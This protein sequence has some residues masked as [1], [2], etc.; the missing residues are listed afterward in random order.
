MGLSTGIK[1]PQP[2]GKTRQILMNTS[3]SNSAVRVRDNV[4]VFMPAQ[5]WKGAPS[6]TVSREIARQWR[7]QGLADFVNKG[8]G[9][10]LK[11]IRPPRTRRLTP[12]RTC[13]S[14]GF[15]TICHHCR[16][17]EKLA[18]GSEVVDE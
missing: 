3:V 15:Q 17:D 2:R 16:R 11:S 10:Q 4:G 5:S 12:C 13:G 7:D 9:I 6:F 8:S 18:L 14:W 1:C